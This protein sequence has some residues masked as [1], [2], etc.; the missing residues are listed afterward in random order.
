MGLFYCLILSNLACP[1]QK[2]VN[3]VKKGVKTYGYALLLQAWLKRK[4][5]TN[6]LRKKICSRVFFVKKFF[7][8]RFTERIAFLCELVNV[9]DDT[10][11][12]PQDV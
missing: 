1:Q 3:Y 6:T 10:G 9:D 2:I 11:S 12:N 5:R 7:F 4:H 8:E